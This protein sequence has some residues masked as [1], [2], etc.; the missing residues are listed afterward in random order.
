MLNLILRAAFAVLLICGLTANAEANTWKS[1]FVSGDDSQ[2]RRF[3]FETRRESRRRMLRSHDFARDQK[4]R[5]LSGARP[6]V[7][8]IDVYANVKNCVEKKEQAIG[9]RPS[10]PQAF[11]GANTNGWTIL[12]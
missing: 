7:S 4:R 10:L 3:I 9:V 11:F 5:I 2:H 12:E 6:S 8:P 1:I